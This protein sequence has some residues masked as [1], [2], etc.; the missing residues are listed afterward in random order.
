MQQFLKHFKSSYPYSSFQC[1]LFDI[2]ILSGNHGLS[3][4]RFTYK[5]YKLDFT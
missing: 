1:L 4:F 2:S 3:P 5:N